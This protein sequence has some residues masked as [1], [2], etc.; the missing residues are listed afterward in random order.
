MNLVRIGLSQLPTPLSEGF[1]SD[2]N[3]PV[4]HHFLNISEAERKGIVQPDAVGDDLSRTA[5][6][7]VGNAYPFSVA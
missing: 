6:S 5:M 1:I 7:F 3:I 4:Q 2:L